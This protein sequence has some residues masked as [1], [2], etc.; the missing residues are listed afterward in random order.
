MVLSRDIERILTMMK[1]YV[2]KLISWNMLSAFTQQDR[3]GA[4]H[5][6]GDKAV[7]IVVEENMDQVYVLQDKDDDD[8]NEDQD[9]PQGD[10]QVQMVLPRVDLDIVR[11]RPILRSVRVWL[12]CV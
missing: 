1:R 7:A 11:T 12:W 4:T 10:H 3:N 6:Y 8:T 9:I 5:I 2:D